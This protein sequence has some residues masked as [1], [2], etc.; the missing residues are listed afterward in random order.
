MLD[1]RQTLTRKRDI[2]HCAWIRTLPCVICGDNTT[3]ECCHI[4]MADPELDKPLTGM[5]IKPDDVW[6]LPMCGKHHREQHRNGEYMFWEGVG[7]VPTIMALM[8]YTVSGDNEKAE[9]IIKEWQQ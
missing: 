4:R 3:V 5:G 6:T 9:Q 2:K 8:L 7:L 1:G